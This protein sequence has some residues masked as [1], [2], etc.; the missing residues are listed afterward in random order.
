MCEYM[1]YC[2]RM[3]RNPGLGFRAWGRGSLFLLSGLFPTAPGFRV[4]GLVKGVS[5]GGHRDRRLFGLGTVCNLKLLGLSFV[6]CAEAVL[7]YPK[8]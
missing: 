8:P 7:G 5:G 6:H 4:Q 3:R 2:R 1:P